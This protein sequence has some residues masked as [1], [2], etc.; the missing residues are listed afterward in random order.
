[1]RTATYAALLVVA[2]AL[3]FAGCTREITGNVAQADNSSDDC[4]SCHSDKDVFL[5]VAQQQFANSAHPS[6]ENTDRNRLN[7][8][9]Y[10]ACE[11]CH[12]HEGFVQEWAEIH[13]A[14]LAANSSSRSWS[15]SSDC[16]SVR[17]PASY[18]S[19]P[20]TI[21]SLRSVSLALS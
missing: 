17:M 2:V 1:M 21:V 13:G 7:L 8:S 11:K 6:G 12:T 10:Q 9:F 20:P 14:T 3:V 19:A 18:F 15:A 4:F 5:Q 16:A